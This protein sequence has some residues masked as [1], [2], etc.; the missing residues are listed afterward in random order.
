MFSP[1]ATQ[2]VGDTTVEAVGIERLCASVFAFTKEVSLPD[3][4]VGPPA[5][6]QPLEPVS[7]PPPGMRK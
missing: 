7:N 5:R 6:V 4:T 1:I 3:T 2:T